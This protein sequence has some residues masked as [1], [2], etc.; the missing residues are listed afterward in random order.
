MLPTGIGIL[1]IA[2][3]SKETGW[4][5]S[6]E[7][8]AEHLPFPLEVAYLETDKGTTIAEGVRRLERMN[9]SRILAIPLFVSSGSAHLEEIKYA[10][11]LVSTPK[12]E[13]GLDPIRTSAAIRLSPAMDDHPCILE[14]IRERIASLSQAPAGENLLLVA[15]GSGHPDLH[16]IWEET[17]TRMAKH[18]QKL[19]RFQSVSYATVHP[20]TIREQA[21]RMS[22]N[23]LLVIPLFL[24]EGYFTRTFIRSQLNGLNFVYS[25]Q[26]YLPH[27]MLSNWIMQM[28]DEGFAGQHSA[29]RSVDLSFP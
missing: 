8:L 2:H 29:C 6:V 20:N 17:L 27:P 28:A 5:Q 1:L 15:H 11:G 14:I 13:T 24:S 23:R 26:A 10:L 4:M 7:E 16:P 22:A 25:G 12:V 21:E 9:A 18:F 3:G 19:D